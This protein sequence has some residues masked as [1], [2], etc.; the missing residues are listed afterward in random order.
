MNF[1]IMN[2]QGTLEEDSE[3]MS[4]L[5]H[6]FVEEGYTDKSRAKKIFTPTEVRKRGDIILARSTEGK[7]VG[8]IIFVHS[9]S[10]SCQVA[11]MDEAEIQ[12]LAVY[13]E[14]RGQGIATRLIITC[15]QRATSFGYSKMV[16]STQQTMKDA[17]HV[18][19]Q[20]G[21]RR[22]SLRDWSM[23]ENRNFCVYEKF[24]T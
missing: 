4:L 9:T 13:P 3:I 1:Q 18:Y 24:L 6:V 7:L 12:L 17:H 19:E 21:Y 14:A 11:K 23:E 16:L 15:E 22:N 10:P 5:I 2:H 20:L 8:M